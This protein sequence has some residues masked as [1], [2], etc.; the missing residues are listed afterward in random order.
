MQGEPKTAPD[1][2]E[3]ITALREILTV[4]SRSR[5]NEAPVF[6]AIL[7]SAAR[8]CTAPMA[9]LILATKDDTHQRL[10]AH[11]GVPPA[12]VEMFDTGQMRVDRDLSYAARS[13]TDGRLIAFPDMRDSDLYAAGSPVVRPMVDVS[14]IRS[15]LFVPLM[16]DGAAIGTITVFRQAVDPFTDTEIAL[17]ETFAAQAVIAIDNVRQFREL[18]TRLD[19][20]KASA[21][22]LSV[23]SQSRDDEAPV[24]D[25]IVENAARLCDAHRVGL[26][27]ANAARTRLRY[28]SV[29]GGKFDHFHEGFEFDLTGPLQVARTVREA[30][31]IHTPDLADDPLYTARD[32]VRV[33]IVEEVGVRTFL[34]VP[35]IRDGVALGCLN[36]NRSEVR[37]FSDDEI[38]LIETFAAQ[39]VIAIDNVRQFRALESLNAELSDRVSEQVDEIA[40]M[41]RLKR[42]L[43]PA[44]ADAVVSAGSED[45]LASHRALIAVLFA[46]IRGFTAFCET[47]EPEETI[48]VLQTYHEEMGRLIHTHG[49]G[50]DTRS[51]DGIMVIMGDPLPCDDPAGDALILALAMRDRMAELSKGWRQL[52]HRLGFG[53]G[54]SLG[55]ATVGMVGA[56]GRYDYTASGTTVNLAARLC[57]AA[58]NGDIL[59]SP[60]A[61]TA[62]DDRVTADSLGAHEFKGIKAPVEVYRVASAPE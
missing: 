37:P 55:Y 4:I 6:E 8:L 14:G 22:I 34:T 54:L 53:V 21:E 45:M 15:V 1:P 52:G 39:A 36:L 59:L 41:G 29:W 61:F 30:R 16:T 12:T 5:G 32:P 51:G 23:I 9:G 35:L 7:Q 11:I 42:F 10:A 33:K 44:V 3:D 38:A 13:I 28:V 40:R 31:V 56:G 49:A 2:Q 43:S 18:Q 46:D 57:D 62:L 20:E 50:V 27:L 25:A 26:S 19:R 60:R 24:L 47:A 58:G 17:I 48:E